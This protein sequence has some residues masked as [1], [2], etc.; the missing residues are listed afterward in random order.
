MV[1][2][3]ELKITP[4]A[5]YKILPRLGIGAGIPAPKKLSAASK[6]MAIAKV[7][8]PCTMI[9]ERIFGRIW[10][11]STVRVPAPCDLIA[12]IYVISFTD[13]V[14]ALAT[15]AITGV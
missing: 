10:E 9:G 15:L 8:V 3:Q 13:N 2:H 1:I 6:M 5:S 11:N 7:Y 12:S 14:E 4:L